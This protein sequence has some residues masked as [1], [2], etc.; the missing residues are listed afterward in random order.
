MLWSLSL[1]LVI[2]FLCPGG[3][4]GEGCWTGFPPLFSSREEVSELGFPTCKG[5]RGRLQ[6]CKPWLRHPGGWMLSLAAG[7][8]L[9][10]AVPCAAG[11]GVSLKNLWGPHIRFLPLALPG[12]TQIGKRWRWQRLPLFHKAT[13]SWVHLLSWRRLVPSGH[14][15]SPVCLTYT[16]GDHQ[17]VLTGRKEMAGLHR[18]SDHPQQKQAAAAG[19]PCLSQNLSLEDLEK[20]RGGG[21]T[22]AGPHSPS[23]PRPIAVAFQVSEAGPG[24]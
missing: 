14:V 24:L 17:F 1:S 7:G 20:V 21:G 18:R 6:C 9:V 13:P 11:P 16:F 5:D 15:F 8:L 19:H 4:R 22:R 23:I 12:G 3:V 10:R 2:F